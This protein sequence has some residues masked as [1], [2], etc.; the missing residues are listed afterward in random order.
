[1]AYLLATICSTQ[2]TIVRLSKAAEN[3][4]SLVYGVGMIS[5]RVAWVDLD[6]KRSLLIF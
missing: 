1:M 3:N 2:S 6:R 4:S 5:M